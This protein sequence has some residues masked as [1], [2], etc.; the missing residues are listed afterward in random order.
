MPGC[1]TGPTSFNFV[2]EQPVGQ[3]LEETPQDTAP[4]AAVS[5]ITHALLDLSVYLYVDDIFMMHLVP[6]GA[7]R[8]AAPALANS[9]T[10]LDQCLAEY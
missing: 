2:Y 7:A 8:D 4:F 6:S 1:S 10:I 3:W 5:P 9:N